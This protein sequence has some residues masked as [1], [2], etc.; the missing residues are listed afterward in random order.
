MSSI[1]ENTETDIFNASPDI[2][3]DLWTCSSKMRKDIFYFF[4]SKKYFKIVEIGGHKGYTTKILSN[5]FSKVY[6]VDNNLNYMQENK[7][8]NKNS[9]NIEYVILDIYKN[10]WRILPEDIDIVFIDADHSYLC[11]KSDIINS[12]NRFKNLSYIIFDDYGV[13]P[14]VKQAINE[15]INNKILLFET[16]IGLEDVPSEFGIAKNTHE[17]II[18]RVNKNM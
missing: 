11:C 12:I 13:W 4:I 16:Y 7:I 9:S 10:N 3:N 2:N 14:G 8:F 15:F 18:C 6:T 17:G 1:F 5:I